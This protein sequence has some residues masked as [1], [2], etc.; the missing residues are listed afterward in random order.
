MQLNL[1]NKVALVTGASRGIGRA[2]ALQLA[3]EGAKLAIGYST[4]G[5]LA[6]EVVSEIK[7]MGGQAIAVQADNKDYPSVQR[8]VGEVESEYGR[9]DVLVNN[10][11]QHRGRAI[12]K[13]PLEDWDTVLYS[14]LFGAFYYCREVVPIMLKNGYG[15]IINISSVV[16]IR[17]WPGDAAY[18]S[19]K[20]GM[21]GFTKSTARELAGQGINVN[22]IICGYVKT[23]M[24][25]TINE[26]NIKV[27]ES[28]IPM[29]RSADADEIA[30]AVTFLAGSG[31][32]ITGA[33][34]H[35][36]GGMGM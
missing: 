1:E 34:L 20:A 31:S 11:G 33:I 5:D 7:K 13:L 26:K 3:R 9:I 12:H 36:D 18:G 4:R 28:M 27:I 21:L 32:Y 14:H 2:I 24:T 16:A 19:A 22:A 29:K 15:R 23:D 6:Q 8:L 25:A 30:E 35:V 17:G 10:A